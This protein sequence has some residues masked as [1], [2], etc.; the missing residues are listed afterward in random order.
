MAERGR[1]EL[2]VL[3]RHSRFPGVRFKPLSHLSTEHAIVEQECRSRN[4]FHT[5]SG[6]ARLPGVQKKRTIV[7]FFCGPLVRLNVFDKVSPGF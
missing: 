5:Q 6:S 7:R 2:P 3:F 4:A 1:F